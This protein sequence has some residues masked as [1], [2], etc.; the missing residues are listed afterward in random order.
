MRFLGGAEVSEVVFWA[1]WVQGLLKGL[2]L[3]KPK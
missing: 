3:V 2:Q 1:L